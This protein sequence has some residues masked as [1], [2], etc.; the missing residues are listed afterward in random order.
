[1]KPAITLGMCAIALGAQPEKTW[2]MHD[3]ERPL[4]P[5]VTPG[6]TS[7]A[8]PADA[9]V[10]LGSRG[11]DAWHD[12]SG[13]ALAWDQPEAG[14]I[15]PAR[16]TGDAHSRESFGECQL[17]IEWMCPASELANSGQSRGNSGVFFMG[18]YEVQILMSHDN[19]TY[20]DGMAGSLYGQHPPLVNAC[21]GVGEWNT[22][23]IVFRRP[24]FDANGEVVKP[25]VVTLLMNGVLVQDH[26]ELVGP[27]S[28]MT[29]AAYQAHEDS[30]PIRLQNHGQVVHFRNI[31]VRR[32]D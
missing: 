19:R 8:A 9:V 17:H 3:M 27:T 2:K 28:H 13:G 11:V 18:R 4:P 10:L 16:N 25:A 7:G 15:A 29:Q 12:G 21:R 31:W 6:A 30:L 20:A 23:D 5:V 26:A 24:V 14:V 22:Y 1:M 32:L